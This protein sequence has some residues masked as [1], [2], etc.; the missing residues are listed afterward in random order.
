MDLKPTSL[1]L[2]TSGAAPSCFFA[3]G[4][5]VAGQQGQTPVPTAPMMNETAVL[6]TQEQGHATCPRH[7]APVGG[8]G[9]REA[10][11]AQCG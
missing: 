3:N 4:K 1:G 2:C 6:E 8:A 7:C 9:Y 11:R 5:H 10:D